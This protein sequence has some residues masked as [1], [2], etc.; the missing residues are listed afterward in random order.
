MLGIG[1]TLGALEFRSQQAGP[2]T[3]TTTSTTAVPHVKTVVRHYLPY[4]VDG[5]LTVATSA[6]TTG[7]CG[8][9][10][11]SPRSDAHRC[12]TDNKDGVNLFD[13]CFDDGIGLDQA[14]CPDTTPPIG[15][16]VVVVK[17]NSPIDPPAAPFTSSNSQVEPWAIVLDSQVS[18]VLA[19]GTR[20]TVGDLGF[21]YACNDG[22]A[23]TTPT[24][25]DDLSVKVLDPRTNN[26]TDQHVTEALT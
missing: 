23:A 17:L 2:P 24:G 9:S 25:S 18:C 15:S 16:Q 7:R 3:T 14:A 10:S 13:P 1:A 19:G 6:Q 26:L 20:P 11:S 5:T 4:R 21:D 12:F 8:E 22:T